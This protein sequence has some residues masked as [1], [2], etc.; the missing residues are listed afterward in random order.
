MKALDA[1]LAS[2]SPAPGA[3][4]PAATSGPAVSGGAG[5]ATGKTSGE[6]KG[7]AVKEVKE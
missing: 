4:S 5:V 3:P 1:R 2:G 6:G 7:D